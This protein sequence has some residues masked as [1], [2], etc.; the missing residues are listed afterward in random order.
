MPQLY[1]PVAITAICT[2]GFRQ[3]ILI[4]LFYKLCWQEFFQTKM[5][6]DMQLFMRYTNLCSHGI[7]IPVKLYTLIQKEN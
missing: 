5:A 7:A 6:L 3:L 2:K 4:V 1:L